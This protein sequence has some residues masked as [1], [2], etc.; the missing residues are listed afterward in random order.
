MN[1]EIPFMVGCKLNTDPENI[2]FCSDPA[3]FEAL[4]LSGT[5]L[6][7]LTGNHMNDFGAVFLRY[8]S[9]STI[10]RVFTT[11]AAGAMPSPAPCA[12]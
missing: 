5:T 8:A 4:K 1:N 11:T 2:I 10:A 12:A 7:G 9:N 3:Y 6:V